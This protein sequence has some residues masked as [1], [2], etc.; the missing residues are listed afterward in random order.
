MRHKAAYSVLYTIY[1]HDC[2]ATH[3][4]NTIIK[5]ADDTTVVGKILNN[6]ETAYRGEVDRLVGYGIRKLSI[7][8]TSNKGFESLKMFFLNTEKSV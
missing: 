3:P 2:V 8:L 1:T 7:L 5:F 4:L 6:N